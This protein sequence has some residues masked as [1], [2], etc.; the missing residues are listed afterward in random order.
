MTAAA[1]TD[2]IPSLGTLNVRISPSATLLLLRMQYWQYSMQTTTEHKPKDSAS[3]LKVLDESHQDCMQPAGLQE[4]ALQS[5]EPGPVV[6]P[7]CLW[8]LGEV[9]G[10]LLLP[11]HVIGVWVELY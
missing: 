5:V 3:A 2:L 10:K 7:P 4:S 1:C 9:G 11:L 6:W 8:W